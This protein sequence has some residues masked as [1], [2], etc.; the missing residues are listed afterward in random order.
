[1]SRL[2]TS[3]NFQT[4]LEHRSLREFETFTLEIKDNGHID[5][6]NWVIFVYQFTT[7]TRIFKTFTCLRDIDVN[8]AKICIAVL[9]ISSYKWLKTRYFILHILL[10][11]CI[12]VWYFRG[13]ILFY[14]YSSSL[15][16]SAIH[17]IFYII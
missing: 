15:T 14:L 9:A 5:Y 7:T 16:T 2:F 12:S 13:M 6:L 1:M 17:F 4:N 3:E 11:E 10:L 8:T